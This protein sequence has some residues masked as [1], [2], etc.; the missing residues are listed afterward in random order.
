M[1][2]PCEICWTNS[3]VPVPTEEECHFNHPHPSLEHHVR[4]DFCWLHG[5]YRELRDKYIELLREKGIQYDE[6][7]S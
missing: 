6:E 1:L 4:C 2:A 7:K 5:Q 3:W